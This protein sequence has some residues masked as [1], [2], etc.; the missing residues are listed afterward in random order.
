M[1]I[2]KKRLKRLKASIYDAHTRTHTRANVSIYPDLGSL[3]SLIT[4]CTRCD[5][6][7]LS[8]ARSD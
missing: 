5:Q 6:A 3:E 1:E 2:L 8:S 4:P 7:F